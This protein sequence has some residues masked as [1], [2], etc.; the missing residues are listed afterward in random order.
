MKES[1]RYLSNAKEI[2]RKAPIEDN[3]YTDVKYVQE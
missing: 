1:L 2:L 3:N